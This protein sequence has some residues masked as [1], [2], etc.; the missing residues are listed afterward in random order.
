MH[1]TQFYHAKYIFFF[2][3]IFILKSFETVD[4]SYNMSLIIHCMIQNIKLGFIMQNTFFFSI[5]CI[6]KPLETVVFSY[7][8]VVSYTLYDTKKLFGLFCI[9][10]VITL[11]AL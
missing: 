7:S 11:L 5:I 8:Y 2:I 6:L 1:I 10:V 3:I 4:F 9:L